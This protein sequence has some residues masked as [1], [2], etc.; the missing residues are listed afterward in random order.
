MLL[1]FDAG[2][3]MPT[4]VWKSKSR[5]ENPNQTKDLS[6]I[7]PTPF[8]R[9]GYVYGICSYGEMRCLRLETGERIWESLQ[10][11]GSQKKAGDRWKNA[12][13][14]PHDDDVF[15]FNEAGDLIIARLTPKGYDEVSRAHLLKPTNTMVSARPVLWSHPAFANK[16]IYARNDKEIVCYSLAAE[17]SRNP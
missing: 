1:R 15:V 17:E 6:S 7:I 12:F 9:S 5:G 13:L 11:T 4:V 8:I 14:V 10:A 16:S 2:A 3:A